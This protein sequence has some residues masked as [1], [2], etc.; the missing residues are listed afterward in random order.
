MNATETRVAIVGGGKAG[1]DFLRMLHDVPARFGLS[2]V[3]LAD[4]DPDSAGLHLAAELGVPV[5]TS[6]FR[7]LLR[8]D[9]IDL[10]V[11]LT[12]DRAVS[13][14]IKA[15][16]PPHMHFVD[17]Y[18]S[19]FFW[20][21]FDRIE[22]SDRLRR[23]AVEK[24][25]FERN[26][27][28]NILDSLPFEILVIGIDYKVQL[29]N[30][31]FLENNLLDLDE[32]I[33]RYCYDVEMLTRGPCDVSVNGCPHNSTLKNGRAVST[34]VS[35]VDDDGEEHFASLRAAPIRDDEGR[36]L[37]VVESILDI[38][39]RVQIE[40]RLKR[41]RQ[42]LDRFLDTA[43][44]L[45]Y[46]T[47]TAHRIRRANRFALDTL[48]LKDRQV[49]GNTMRSLLPEPAAAEL[50]AA[51]RRVLQ[52]GQSTVHEGTFSLGGDPLYYRA[53]LFPVHADDEVVG[54]FNLIENTTRLTESERKLA[55]RS[56]EL[57]EARQLLDGVLDNSRDLIF[58]TDAGGDLVSFNRGAENALGY[59]SAEVMG[60]PAA[61]FCRHPGD[62]RELFAQCLS[63]GHS[64]RFEMPLVRRDGET[65]ICNVS[66]TT[67]LEQAEAER[68]VVAICRDITTRRRL[69]D[70][71]VRSDRLAALGKMAAGVAH[72]INN[73]LAVM[74]SI[75]GVVADTLEEEGDRLSESNR[76]LLGKA[77]E[78][79]HAQVKR[80]SNITHGLLGFA[81][82]SESDRSEVDIQS[83]L[84]E[85]LELLQAELKGVGA[86]VVRRFAGDLPRVVTSAPL[87][88]QVLVNLIKNACDAIEETGRGSGVLTVSLGV[89]DG[90]LVV[91]VEDDGVGIPAEELNK[92][93]DLFQTSK[94]VGKGTGLGLSIVHDIVERLGAEIQV[95]S[96]PGRW[97]RFT[98]L[99]PLETPASAT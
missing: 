80:C 34:V 43:P 73:P 58:L 5:L 81:R 12:G 15:D 37:G 60:R 57:S 62:F 26:R 16:L 17:H 63:E 28:Q 89:A 86:D 21:L 53:T 83:L 69:Q 65:V 76:D 9:D 84:E 25:R 91:E 95:R 10:L 6:D 74:E 97:T 92:I 90:R 48:A 36:V 18:A 49:I 33:G 39:D 59:D 93:F 35:V 94:P 68:E 96:E 72:E 54:L 46:Q 24:L 85:C 71:L 1:L 79:L 70:D 64:E 14:A 88:Q 38:S 61:E 75:A 98:L 31:T 82:K 11:E 20:D 99:L 3:G 44:M 77:A 47:D 27:L 78:R 13:D 45:I 19:R 67:I 66:L 40:S 41:T 2:V 22:R 7:D 52:S 29:A 30:R 23:E 50:H 87:V 42:S 8:R 51:E 55:Q 56:A 4:P 32:V